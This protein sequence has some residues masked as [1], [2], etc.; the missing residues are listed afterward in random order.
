FS[1]KQARLTSAS[2]TFAIGMLILF[3]LPEIRSAAS[4][5]RAQTSVTGDTPRAHEADRIF[6]SLDQTLRILPA[7]MDT[8]ARS[9]AISKVNE[10]QLSTSL[11]RLMRSHPELD[12]TT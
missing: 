7:T 12:G 9:F 3:L 4:S 5:D 11:R 1:S 8:S 10:Q 2:S 6:H